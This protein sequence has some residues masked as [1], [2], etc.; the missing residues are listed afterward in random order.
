VQAVAA[1]LRK[2]E[3]ASPA[4]N[5]ATLAMAD[6]AQAQLQA[7]IAAAQGDYATAV[8]RQQAALDA[9]AGLDEREPPM[10]AGA[11]RIGLGRLQVRA[12]RWQ[13]AELTFRQAL[14]DAPRSGWALRG[15]A[16]S[17]AGQGRDG[18][19]AAV[20]QQLDRAWPQAPQRLRTAG[21]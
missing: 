9:S 4:G 5:A 3:G 14:A 18:E 7:E 6:F 21:A 15:L 16:A 8:T 12:G 17:L 1:A 13:D 2:E 10:L 20:R 11:A 19:A